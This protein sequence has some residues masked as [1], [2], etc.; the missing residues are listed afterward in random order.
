VTEQKQS[1]SIELGLTLTTTSLSPDRPLDGKVTLR[2]TGNAAGVQFHLELKGFAPDSYEL[3]PGPILFPNA[4]AELAL[5]LHHPRSPEM[6]AGN[7]RITIRATAPLAYPNEFAEVS[8]A[9]QVMPFFYHKL[10][11]IPVER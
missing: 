10:R 3:E 11:L 2:N 9:I 1:E 4:D 5:R 7:H 6:V 8:R